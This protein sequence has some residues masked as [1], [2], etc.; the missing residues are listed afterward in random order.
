MLVE[1]DTQA[2]MMVSL[3][4]GILVGVNRRH[5]AVGSHFVSFGQQI[6][7]HVPKLQYSVIEIKQCKMF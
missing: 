1:T 6:N 7:F 3:I 4:A 2:V 5:I